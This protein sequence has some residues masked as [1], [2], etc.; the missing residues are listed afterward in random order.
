MKYPYRTATTVKAKPFVILAMGLLAMSMSVQAAPG[1]ITD[2][3]MVWL[4]ADTGISAI[5]GGPVFSWADQSGEGN[6]ALFNPVNTHFELPPILVDS[7][8]GAA[9]QSTVRFDNTNALELNLEFLAG[10]DY[11]IFVV[12]GRDRFGL[13]NFY[14]AGAT[15]APNRNLTLGYEQIGLLRQAHF[16]NDLDAFVTNYDGS[17]IWALDTFSFDQN[18][19]RNLYQD[20]VLLASDDNLIP[21]IDNVGTT[22]GHFRAFGPLFWFQGDLAEIVIYDRA[23][24]EIERRLV[25]AELA[26]LYGRP[27]DFDVLEILGEAVVGVGPGKSLANKIALAQSYLAVPDLQSAC[28][29]LNDFLNQVRAQRGKK[30]TPSLADE[31]TADA[32]AI[33]NANGCN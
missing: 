31:L 19:G 1:G 27:Y 24:T 7:N 5:A 33:M 20:G 16:A 10:S 21:L 29:I 11:T 9:G 23:L 26:A 30:I 4:R 13:A 12:N 2:G 17:P 25:E 22:L 8:P 28:S 15:A 14:I 32:V 6:D 3:L 18:V